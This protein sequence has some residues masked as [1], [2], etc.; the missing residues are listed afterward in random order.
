MNGKP[1]SPTTQKP[2]EYQNFEN[3]LKQVASVP[4]AEVDRRIQAEKDAR[5]QKQHTENAK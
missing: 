1:P 2:E 3:L 5:A 4:K